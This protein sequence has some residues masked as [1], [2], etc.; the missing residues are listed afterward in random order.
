MLMAVVRIWLCRYF[1]VCRQQIV[2]HFGELFTYDYI[3]FVYR[4]IYAV[5]DHKGANQN[6][7]RSM[8]SVV[9][10]QFRVKFI[11]LL[12]A[13]SVISS[14][15]MI[16]KYRWNDKRAPHCSCTILSVISL[17]KPDSLVYVNSIPIGRKIN[18]SIF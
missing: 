18:P 2:T 7:K 5:F 17:V 15:F 6:S 16:W 8:S 9:F 3:L 1:G 12:A 10:R 13:E 4:K 14:E 11:R